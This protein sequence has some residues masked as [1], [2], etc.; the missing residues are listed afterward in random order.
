MLLVAI[1]GL[2]HPQLG[3]HYLLTT[4]VVKWGRKK[5]T[6]QNID[7]INNLIKA[8]QMHNTSI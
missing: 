7:K 4:T 2:Q 6:Q 5:R 1:V 3:W 8:N